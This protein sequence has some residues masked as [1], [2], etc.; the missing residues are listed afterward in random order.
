MRTGLFDE[1]STIVRGRCERT[2][3]RGISTGGKAAVHRSG[4]RDGQTAERIVELRL[5]ARNAMRALPKKTG[6]RHGDQ[7]QA[8]TS[9][10]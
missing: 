5:P 6:N 4:T 10:P 2:D 1:E 7:T 8:P 9:S 3:R